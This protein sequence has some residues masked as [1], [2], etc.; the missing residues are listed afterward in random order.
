M[1]V[2]HA[3]WESSG[4]ARF[5]FWAESAELPAGVARRG[6]R[7]SITIQQHPFALTTGMLQEALGEVGGSLLVGEGAT[8]VLSLRLPTTER[9]PLASPELVREE[10][11]DL[12]ATA[13]ASWEVPALSLSP[14]GA[15][16]LLLALPDALPEG[17][18]AGS[19]LRFWMTAA[20][21]AFELLV[22]Q[23][24]VPAL[25]EMPVEDAVSLRAAWEAVLDAEDTARVRALAS[26]MPAVC[27]S[28]LAPADRSATVSQDLLVSFLN[29]TI[30]A[31]VRLRLSARDMLPDVRKRWSKLM[32]LP[33]QWLRAL[34]A[35][36]PVLEAEPSALQPFAGVL[37]GWL[38]QLHAGERDAAFRTCFRLDQPVE[39]EGEAQPSTDW[40]VSFYLQAN[41]DRSL[42]VPA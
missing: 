1:I 41:D 12:P 9:G 38:D 6:R 25:W 39:E 28:L 15:L 20:R 22:R 35:A 19:S 16:D 42:L 2:L 37:R 32:P 8:G 36:N 7:S 17:L 3:L 34:A 13:F 4:E 23:C 10:P 24:Y 33:E 14:D 30:D 40:L 18:V 29:H 21:L 27:R 31:F 26:L 5:H 11:V